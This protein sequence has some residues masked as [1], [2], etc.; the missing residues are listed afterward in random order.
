MNE[1]NRISITRLLLWT[2]AAPVVTAWAVLSFLPVFGLFIEGASITSIVGDIL[3]LLFGFAGLFGAYVFAIF[4]ATGRENKSRISRLMQGR[5]GF[6]AAY[7][8]IW[9]TAYWLFKYFLA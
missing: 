6:L 5:I 8:T 1:R 4:C 9:L 3:F 7:A 2:Y